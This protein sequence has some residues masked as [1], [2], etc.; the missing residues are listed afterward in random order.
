[1][2]VFQNPKKSEFRDTSVPRISD[3]GR[4]TCIY[5]LKSLPEVPV[6]R[7]CNRLPEVPVLRNCNRLFPY[8]KLL[9]SLQQFPS[10]EAKGSQVGKET[11]RFLLT[12]ICFYV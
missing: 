5:V 11:R 6:L 7:N 8:E 3:N 2:Q 10:W 4:S 12:K 9:N 1:M